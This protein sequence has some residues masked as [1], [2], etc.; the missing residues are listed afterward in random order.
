MIYSK[1]IDDQKGNYHSLSLSLF[2]RCV[3][4]ILLSWFFRG[5][6]NNTTDKLMLNSPNVSQSPR[7]PLLGFLHPDIPAIVWS[8]PT[9][10]G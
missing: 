5:Y 1:S 3:I 2:I 7:G 4:F 10:K 6:S 8:H 9:V